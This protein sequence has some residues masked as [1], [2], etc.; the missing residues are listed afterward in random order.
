MLGLTSK[1]TDIVRKLQMRR[2]LSDLTRV[3]MLAPV[4]TEAG[5]RDVAIGFLTCH[6]HLPL[7]ML[8]AKSFFHFSGIVCPMYIWNDGS[9]TSR[10]RGWIRRL[11]PSA[12]I[13]SRSDLDL[14]Q[15]AG[16]PLTAS[17]A[18]GVLKP[19]E[20]YAPAL[21]ICGPLLSPGVPDRVILSDS[22]AFFFDWPEAIVEWLDDPQGGSRY[23]AAWSGKDNLGELQLKDLYRRLNISSHPR[24]NSG[25]LLLH[26]HIF[27]LELIERI[28]EWYQERPYIWDM[29]QTL[30]G[31][32]MACTNSTP[33]SQDEYVLCHR[34]YSAICHHFFTSVIIDE[35]VVRMKILNLL[36]YIE[37]S[38]KR[39][40]P[41]VSVAQRKHEQKG[42]LIGRGTQQARC[43]R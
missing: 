39:N 11:F 1:V 28:L 15:L 7:M 24:A 12:L 43:S 25:L 14:E 42:Q 13:L 2:F 38:E 37:D 40:K 23:I 20:R 16:Y 41:P 31:I 6:G 22:D 21:K 19:Y 17:L 3:E 5:R 35:P 34:K 4:D 26:R 32:L 30:Y 33:L 10:D 8:A 27:N 36:K 29:E 18:R 9:L